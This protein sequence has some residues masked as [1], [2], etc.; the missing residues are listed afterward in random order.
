[1][2]FEADCRA[3][4][5]CENAVGPLVNCAV[6]PDLLAVQNILDTLATRY[7]QTH[8]YGNL[9]RRL[10]ATFVRLMQR[11]LGID[12]DLALARDAV[13]LAAED[14]GLVNFDDLMHDPAAVELINQLLG[15]DPGLEA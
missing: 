9:F 7:N 10:C 14:N 15:L 3:C 6:D 2:P 4:P 12:V 5:A 13:G 11:M 1:L 8:R